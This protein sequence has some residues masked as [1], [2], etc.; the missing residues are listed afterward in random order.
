MSLHLG[1][2]K[3]SRK[4]FRSDPW[5]AEERVFSRF[6]A[7]IDILQL[8][9][10]KPRVVLYHGEE[11]ALARGELVLSIRLAAER[12]GWG[13]KGTR[14]FL[15]RAQERARLT[16]QR[17]TQAGTVYLVVNY[18]A[19]QSAREPKD[20]PE[21]TPKGTPEGEARAHRGHTEGTPRAQEGSSKAVQAVKQVTT[22]PPS[23]REVVSVDPFFADPRVIAFL[24]AVPVEKHG[25]WAAILSQWR[26]GEGWGAGAKPTDAQIADGLAA[27]VTAK[28][29]GPMGQAFVAGC[30]RRSMQPVRAVDPES[31]RPL[32]YL[33]KVA[34]GLV[35]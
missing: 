32:T 1:H 31:G 13:E 18:D 9:A 5:W 30:V 2:I 3:L 4:L 14:L 12:W 27:A 10:W 7:W 35:A 16:A 28:D 6:E 17:E 20:T 19:Y 22:S 15:K 8:A 11:I 26:A 24:G 25:A 29:G 34:R 23:A 21:G 33:D